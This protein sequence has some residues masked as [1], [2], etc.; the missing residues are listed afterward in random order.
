M[1]KLFISYRRDDSA[2]VTGRIYDRLVAKFGK[3]TVFKD[4]E[5]IPLG[6]N[7]KTYLD[8]VMRECAVAVVIIGQQW[9]T[10][11]DEHGKRR[12]DDPRDIVRL[13]VETALARNIPVIPLLVQSASMPAEDALPPSL[14]ELAY[15][16]GTPIRRDPDFHRDMDR[17]EEALQQ[18]LNPGA[19]PAKP[20]SPTRYQKGQRVRHWKFGDGLVMSSAIREGDEEVSVMFKEHGVRLLSAALAKLIVLDGE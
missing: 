2:D 13:E 16:N 3:D 12:L 9:L 7:F 17:V 19:K 10:I 15:R 5:S 8:G 18:W 20:A 6:T 4:V 14:A 11:L 1:S